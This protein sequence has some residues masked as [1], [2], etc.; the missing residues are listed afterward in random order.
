ME[1]LELLVIYK[2]EK[3]DFEKYIWYYVLS[4]NKRKFDMRI[5]GLFKLF[6][7]CFDFSEYEYNLIFVFYCLSL[8]CLKLFGWI[9]W[10]ENNKRCIY[11][12]VVCLFFWG[13]IV[14]ICVCNF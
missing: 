5:E 3:V 10:I 13:Y 11:E 2:L 12:N 9:F 14:V 6:I 7:F 8:K 4:M 1:W